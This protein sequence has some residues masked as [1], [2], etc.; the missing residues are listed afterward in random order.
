MRALPKQRLATWV[1]EYGAGRYP[2]TVPYLCRADPPVLLVSKPGTFA[3]TKLEHNA[4]GDKEPPLVLSC[5]TI[6]EED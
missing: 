2:L 4:G 3:H 1:D 5:V 6:H